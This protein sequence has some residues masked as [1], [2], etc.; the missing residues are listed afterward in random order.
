MRIFFLRLSENAKNKRF[1]VEDLHKNF[2]DIILTPTRLTIHFP[3]LHLT[4]V[5]K[6]EFK[7][8]RTTSTIFFTKQNH[9][10]QSTAYELTVP[11]LDIMF[12]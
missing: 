2:S 5:M 7:S 3:H 4:S 6:V 9:C 8:L 10:L 12:I 11:I 1:C